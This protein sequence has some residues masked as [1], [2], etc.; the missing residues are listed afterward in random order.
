MRKSVDDR[1][2]D[3]I[4]QEKY[5]Q[6]PEDEVL[7][8]K[9]HRENYRLVR[10]KEKRIKTL[11]RKLSEQKEELGYLKENLTQSNGQVDHLRKNYKFTCSYIVFSPRPSKKPKS[12]WKRYCNVSVSR[13]GR[14]PHNISCGNV[15]TLKE[16][17]LEYFKNDK[18]HLKSIK[19]DHIQW[20]KT[21][22]KT[23]T[24]IGEERIVYDKVQDLIYKNPIGFDDETHNYN[25]LFPLP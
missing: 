2:L 19:R 4:P 16:H 1:R 21:E 11:L 6:L 15:D 18:F 7:L 10:L 20:M 25:N 23:P 14:N 8:I 5:D 12:E 24:R 22:C 3:F 13:G 17:L 9:Q